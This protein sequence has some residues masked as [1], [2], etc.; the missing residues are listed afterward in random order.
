MTDTVAAL[1][2]HEC[3]DVLRRQRVGRIAVTH[4]AL[5]A[6]VPVNYVLDCHRVV[7]RT[8]RD[9]LLGSTC[10]NAVVAFEVDDIEAK[11]RG[12]LSVLVVGV[13]DV[14]EGSEQLRALELPLV[15]PVADADDVFV[16]VTLGSVTGRRIGVAG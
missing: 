8:R 15:S 4:R 10:R 2:P 6:I 9:G 11:G 14:L 1:G 13:A 12:G 3:L 5:P 16:A 7:F